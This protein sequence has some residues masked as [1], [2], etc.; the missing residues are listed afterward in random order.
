[1][2]GSGEVQMPYHDMPSQLLVQL[3]CS[4]AF[5]WMIKRI[6]KRPGNLLETPLK[7][8]KVPISGKIIQQR[9]CSIASY[10]QYIKIGVC[11]QT[12]KKKMGNV[13][14]PCLSTI[15]DAPWVQYGLWPFGFIFEVFSFHFLLFSLLFCLLSFFPFLL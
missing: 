9:L 8:S 14:D 5:G 7:C 2:R 15:N 11:R 4:R 10:I 13:E 3:P 1:M 6:T 12:K